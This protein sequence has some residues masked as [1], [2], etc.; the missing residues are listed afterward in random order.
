RRALLEDL[1]RAIAAR[2]VDLMRASS[3][4]LGIEV[5]E[6]VRIQGVAAIGLPVELRQPPLQAGIE[7][8]VP[9]RV[10]RVADIHALAV[11]RVLEHLRTA[12]ESPGGLRM[13]A[14]MAEQ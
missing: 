3:V 11:K 14:V 7:L 9:G 2:E 6:E 13:S 8:V 10:Q 1:G 5:D 12:V 4:G